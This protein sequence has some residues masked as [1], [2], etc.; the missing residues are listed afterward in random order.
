MKS[1]IRIQQIKDFKKNTKNLIHREITHRTH[2]D[3]ETVALQNC[4]MVLKIELFSQQKKKS[5]E[6]FPGEFEVKYAIDKAVM[7]TASV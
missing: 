6:L 3:I 5:L 2:I 4:L 1:T 7:N